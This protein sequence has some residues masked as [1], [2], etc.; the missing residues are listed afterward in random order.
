MELCAFPYYIHPE[1]MNSTSRKALQKGIVALYMNEIVYR[2]RPVLGI[3]QILV[4]VVSMLSAPNIDSPANV[5]AGVRF[6]EV[7]YLKIQFRDNIEA[8]KK[9]VK[10][11]TQKSVEDL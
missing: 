10:Q 5:D 3:E 4:S 2:W 9:K 11:L 6:F 7:F 8:Y 1:R